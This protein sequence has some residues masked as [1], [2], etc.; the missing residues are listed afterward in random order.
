M[1][2]K[3][4]NQVV[5]KRKKTSFSMIANPIIDDK[6]ISPAAGWLYVTIQRWITFNVE[7]FVCSKAFIASKYQS[8]YRMFNRAWDELKT[9]GYLKMYSHPTEGWQAELLDEPQADTPHTY[10]LG[11]DGQVKST[12]VDRAEKKAAKEKEKNN[13]TEHYPQNDSNG[14]DNNVKDNNATD[15]NGNDS[16]EK[17]GN[18]INT[19]FKNSFNTVYRDSYQ[20]INPKEENC[21]KLVR[22][23]DNDLIDKIKIQIEYNLLTEESVFRK[24]ISP[25]DLNAAV[26]AIAILKTVSGPQEFGGCTYSDEYVHQRADIINR[27]HIEYVF[28][29]FYENRNKIKNVVSYLKAAIFNAPSTI[30]VYY[31]NEI[32]AKGLV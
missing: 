11:M 25:E 16:D 24:G 3:K 21:N 8:G 9:A 2:Q 6:N 29:C 15:D 30:G 31:Q 22:V 10:Y 19:S 7:G 14:N 17:E 23:I 5:F 4:S 12:N 27:D 13:G 26:E 32:R 18:I 28:E 1:V 20:S